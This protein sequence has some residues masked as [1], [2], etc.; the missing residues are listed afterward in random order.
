MFKR[1]MFIPFHLVDAAGVLFFGHVFTI[2]HQIFECFVI[3]ELDISWSDWFQNS[4]W[5]VPLKKAEADYQYPLKAGF[6]C[7]IELRIEEI[8]SSSFKVRQNFSQK[9]T[10]CCVVNTVHVFCDRST[11]QKIA[12]PEVIYDKMHK[13]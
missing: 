8:R 10:L 11:G 6:V 7:T 5:V 1:E 4:T 9:N 12:I 2:A 13:I 3:E